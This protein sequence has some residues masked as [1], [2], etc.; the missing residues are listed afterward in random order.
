MLLGS[1][2]QARVVNRL[3]IQERSARIEGM[4]VYALDRWPLTYVDASG[5]DLAMRRLHDR[6]TGS[7]CR[8]ASRIGRSS[9]QPCLRPQAIPRWRL[10]HATLLHQLLQVGGDVLLSATP[11]PVRKVGRIDVPRDLRNRGE[12]LR[13]RGQDLLLTLLSMF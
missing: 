11:Q 3:H 10:H 1:Q 6:P 9:K 5:V 12:P 2:M 7:I 4:K 8:P 13:Q